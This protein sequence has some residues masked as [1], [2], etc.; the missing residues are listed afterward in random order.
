MVI[1]F[2]KLMLLNLTF[3]SSIT[4]GNNVLISQG[5]IQL[6]FDDI[7]GFSYTIPKDD[8]AGFFESPV[9]IDQ[10]LKTMLTMKHVVNH[11]KNKNLLDIE[12]INKDVRLFLLE[13]SKIIDGY[14]LNAIEYLKLKKFLFNKIAYKFMH[15][16]IKD[17]VKEEDLYDLADEQY[18]LDKDNYYLTDEL[19]TLQY[20][21]IKFN[22]DT[23]EE[24]K[25]LATNILEELKN[26]SY[27]SIEQKY[28]IDENVIF[29]KGIKDFYFN[30]K[31]EK[32]SEYVFK[33]DS[34]GIIDD[35]LE[36]EKTFIIIELL[37]IIEAGYK[38]FEKVKDKIL[39]GLKKEKIQLEFGNLVST[40]TQDELI[41]ND[42]AIISLKDRYLTNTK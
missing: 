6:T 9:R 14:D 18:I 11:A 33:P 28:S 24:R 31:Y 3:I 16:Y 12:K 37:D 19:R 32:F 36:G 27:E 8:R 15:S 40:L 20:I 5:E 7:D 26:S 34:I 38:P 1:S 25:N 35:L 21:T 41:V 42:N 17:S 39:A 30:K 10:T 13:N 2:I 4:F 29:T 22:E 23:K